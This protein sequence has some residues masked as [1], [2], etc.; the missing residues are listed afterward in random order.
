MGITGTVSA[1]V[2]ANPNIPIG[3][4]PTPDLDLPRLWV[5]NIQC[6]IYTNE[7]EMR[8]LSFETVKGGVDTGEY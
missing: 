1:P 2:P 5:S 8:G 7:K 4:E 3:V 6:R